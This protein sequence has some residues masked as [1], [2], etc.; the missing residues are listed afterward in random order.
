MPAPSIDGFRRKRKQTLKYGLPPILLH[1]I[2]NILLCFAEK[3][4]GNPGLNRFPRVA[5]GK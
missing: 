5:R 1:S 3:D 4:P 2:S